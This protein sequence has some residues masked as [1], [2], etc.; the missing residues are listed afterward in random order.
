M[1]AHLR[2]WIDGDPTDLTNLALLCAYHHHLFHEQH[3]QLAPDPDGGWTAQAPD[4][5]T[6]RRRRR[7]TSA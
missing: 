4:G 7:R 1:P 2:H 6:F 3:W 5:R